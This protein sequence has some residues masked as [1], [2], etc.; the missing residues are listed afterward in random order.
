MIV[1]VRIDDRLLHGQI[2]LSWKSELGYEAIVIADDL[3][4]GDE[5]RK[6]VLKLAVPNGVRLAVRTLDEATNLIKHEQLQKMK[7]LVIVAST[8]SAREFYN[9]IEEKPVLNIGGIQSSDGKRMFSRAVYF[10]DNDIENLD[11][12]QA[13]GVE[14][15]VQEIPGTSKFKYSDLRAKFKGGK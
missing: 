10:D 2:A 13:S 8:K 15:M 11:N 7:V 1:L 14:L 4:S 12:I 3:V 9:R 6:N 5:F